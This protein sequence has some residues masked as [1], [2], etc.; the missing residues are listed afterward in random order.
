M[1][2]ENDII[3]GDNGICKKIE[4]KDKDQVQHE[5]EIFWTRQRTNSQLYK[6]YKVYNLLDKIRF[7]PIALNR[8][9]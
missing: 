4:R 2:I 7:Y 6:L 5:E 1:G 3:L 9:R 8:I